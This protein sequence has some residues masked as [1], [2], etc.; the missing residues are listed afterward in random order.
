MLLC[1]LFNHE[2]AG[3]V[4]VHLVPSLLFFDIGMVWGEWSYRP[5][6]C[7]GDSLSESDFVLVIIS[8]CSR[9]VF[10]EG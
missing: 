8:I 3:G 10:N 7:S 4:I 5:A 9:I 2:D 6:R 1:T